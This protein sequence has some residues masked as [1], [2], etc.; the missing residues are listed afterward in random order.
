MTI[1]LSGAEIDKE[2]RY[3][4]MSRFVVDC[5]ARLES[6]QT[7][8]VARFTFQTSNF[9]LPKSPNTEVVMDD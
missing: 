2:L 7:P 1:S 9:E 8:I 6:K 4:L 5:K 3:G